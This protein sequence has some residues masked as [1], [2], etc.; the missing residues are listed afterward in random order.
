MA[1]GAAKNFYTT[2][3]ESGGP[4]FTRGIFQRKTNGRSKVSVT[5]EGAKYSVNYQGIV[6]KATV[7]ERTRT[8][9]MHVS[10][11]DFPRG[12]DAALHEFNRRIDEVKGATKTAIES[13]RIG[14]RSVLVV[15]L[16]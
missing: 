7:G 16:T 8:C 5:I 11:L 4:N 3:S 2:S 14:A 10:D 1:T 9:T 12:E 13:A 6:Y 15:R